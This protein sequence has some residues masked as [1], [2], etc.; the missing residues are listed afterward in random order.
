MS[1]TEIVKRITDMLDKITREDHL[2]LI[3][4]KYIYIYREV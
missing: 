3:F 1:R 2:N 4:V